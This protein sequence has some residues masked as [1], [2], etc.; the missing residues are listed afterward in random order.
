MPCMVLDAEDPRIN[1]TG[2][3]P[4]KHQHQE[5]RVIP[6]PAVLPHCSIKKYFLLLLLKFS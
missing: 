2:L 6:V 3:R 1:K 4:E 5:G